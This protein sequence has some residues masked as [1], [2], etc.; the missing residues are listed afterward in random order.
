MKSRAGM[1][2]PVSS[3]MRI[4]ASWNAGRPGSAAGT[5]GWKASMTSFRSTAACT[6]WIA[7]LSRAAMAALSGLSL[8]GSSPERFV[9]PFFMPVLRFGASIDRTA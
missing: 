7:F 4:S 3:R 2:R 1:M 9:L 6:I 8:A 5:T